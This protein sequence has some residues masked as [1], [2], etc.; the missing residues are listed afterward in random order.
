MPV[1]FCR[2]SLGGR[3]NNWASDKVKRVTAASVI[4]EQN[5]AF[6]L[7]SVYGDGGLRR[8][9]GD[10]WTPDDLLYPRE[11]PPVQE[12]LAENKARNQRKAR[13]AALHSDAVML[14]VTEGTQETFDAAIAYLTAV[15]GESQ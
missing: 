12:A 15:H 5:G 11:H 4:T 9:R 2:Q 7:S 6:R 13:E 10:A 8:R 3:N 14:W 1:M